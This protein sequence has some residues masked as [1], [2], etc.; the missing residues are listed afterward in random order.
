MLLSLHLLATRN[1]SRAVTLPNIGVPQYIGVPHRVAYPS[2]GDAIRRDRDAIAAAADLRGAFSY[3]PGT[4]VAHHTPDE[5]DW[6]LIAEQPAPAPHL[7]HPEGCAA[8]CTEL[9][10][11]PRVNRFTT[12]FAVIGTRSLLQRT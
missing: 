11:V 9:V 5:R 8:L 2:G 7:A 6:Y 3:E 12:R 1:P 10:T 4:L